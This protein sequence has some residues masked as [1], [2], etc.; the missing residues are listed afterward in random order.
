MSVY[1]IHAEDGLHYVGYTPDERIEERMR[2]HTRAI[3]GLFKRWRERN[4]QWT[5][6]RVWK[7]RGPW[8]EEAIKA[9]KRHALFCPVCSIKPRSIQGIRLRHGEHFARRAKHHGKDID[10]ATIRF[11]VNRDARKRAKQNV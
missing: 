6:V 1:L 9:H 8:T 11:A 4:T 7:R 5:V 2:E 10:A 3:R